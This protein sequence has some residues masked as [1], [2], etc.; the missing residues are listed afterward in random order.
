M[1]AIDYTGPDNRGVCGFCGKLEDGYAMR[2]G[3]GM[4]QAA[5]WPCVNKGREIVPQPKRNPVGITFTEDLD[6]DEKIAKKVK[7]AKKAPGIAPSTNRP[8]TL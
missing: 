8:A 7:A 2:D 6:T 3:T 1:N 4:F 5:C